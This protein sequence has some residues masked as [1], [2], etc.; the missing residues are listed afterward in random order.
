MP[1][2]RRSTIVASQPAAVQAARTPSRLAALAWPLGVFVVA[3]AVRLV[4]LFQMR[5]SPYFT[6]LLGD[7]RGYDEWARRL[8]GGDWIGADV[9]YQAPLYPY[10]L[11]VVY[12]VTGA[13]PANA[14][15]VQAAL[16]SLSAVLL[17][18]AATRLFGRRAGLLAGL[19]LALY[20]PAIFFDSLLQKSVLDIFFVS[21]TLTALAALLTGGHDRRRWWMVLGLAAGALALTRENALVLA[22]V[23]AAWIWFAAPAPRRGR[24]QALAVFAGAV[25]L[26]LAPVAARNFAVSGEVYLTT[27]QFG[28]NFYI[29]NNAG[30]DGSYQPL[31]F[32][33]GS[34]EFEQADATALAE[35]ASGRT[36][37]PAEV[38]S[39]WSGR[40]IAFITGQPDAWLALMAR[41]AALLVNASEAID[42]ES[43]ESYAEWSWPL[44]LLGSFMHF[45]VLV[46][47]AFV[48]TIVTWHDRR[49]LLVVHAMTLA[50][51][52]STVAFYVFARY[53]YP[54][55]PLLMLVAA[56]GVAA[57][58][59]WLAARPRT[60]VI[61]LAA[62]TLAVAGL[63]H[64]PLLSATRSRAITET[65]LGTAFYEA[66]RLDDAMARYR[67]AIEIQPDYVPAFNN[68]G[69]VL[70][71]AGRTDDALGA[72]RQGLALRDDYPDLHYNLA[73]ALLALDRPDEAA[74]HLRQAAAGT[75]DSAGVHNNLGTALAARGQ[76]REAAVE[77]ERAV[78]LEPGSARAHR[79]LGNA[80]AELGRDG[81]A[82]AHLTSA[83]TLA[84]GDAENHYD[85][86][87]YLLTRDRNAEAAAAFTAAIAARPGYAEAHNNLGI[88]IGSQG[89]L[90]RAIAQFEE[91]LRLSPGFEDAARNLD[92]ARRVRRA[93]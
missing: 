9:F 35:R 24:A 25:A 47:L 39:Y 90:G 54:L 49:R 68:L 8:A 13:D 93:Q 31:R 79:N 86:G 73:N 42:T 10:F 12:A 51:A 74:D 65:N 78:L 66:G 22:V 27:S 21:V 34:P 88:A 48:G 63:C 38:S 81:E 18:V 14:R 71:A 32:G 75:P 60:Q 29:G 46:P 7:A 50:L 80:L 85:L 91:A 69:V 23:L 84:P 33:R 59:R 82:F 56:A 41:K 77:F 72:Y 17:A 89:D 67:R 36:L 44:A 87:A 26:V 4:H 92:L 2:R 16:G 19:G 20:A 5:G 70:R 76:F 55:V 83:T 30:A 58:P 3:L 45:G 37:T 64:L 62:G 43:Q 40:A 53:R 11:G 28:P 6:T 57:L 1:R 61:G 52:A 15:L